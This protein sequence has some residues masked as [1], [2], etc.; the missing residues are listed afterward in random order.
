MF[1]GSYTIVGNS[2]AVIFCRKGCLI[3]EL[4]FGV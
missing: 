3:F 1:S 4:F 2:D